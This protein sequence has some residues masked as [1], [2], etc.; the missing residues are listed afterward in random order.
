MNITVFGE[1]KIPL[2]FKYDF[3][4]QLNIKSSKLDI[5]AM[6]TV[7]HVVLS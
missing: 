4:M 3:A 1:K 7:L 6:F 2:I 5:N